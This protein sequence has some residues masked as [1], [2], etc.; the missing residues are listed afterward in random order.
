[1]YTNIV[2]VLRDAGL[3]ITVLRNYSCLDPH[4]CANVRVKKG[5]DGYETCPHIY[6]K[7]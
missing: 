2:F 6:A 1:M 7:K 3:P 4:V 5:T